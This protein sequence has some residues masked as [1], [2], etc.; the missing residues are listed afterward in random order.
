MK[1]TEKTLLRALGEADEKTV[2]KAAP[3]M[4]AED[5]ETLADFVPEQE[6]PPV[7]KRTL[8]TRRITEIGLLCAAIALCVFTGI[9]L[10]KLK[11]SV[12]SDKTAPNVQRAQA[13]LEEFLNAANAG[14]TEKIF[15]LT[16]MQTAF[17]PNYLELTEDTGLLVY[18]FFSPNASKEKEI[19]RDAHAK[20]CDS[21]LYKTERDAAAEA[22]AAELKYD[23]WKI[24]SGRNASDE[25]EIRQKRLADRRD[26]QIFRFRESGE[27]KLAER[28]V[29]R[30]SQ[31]LNTLSLNN[32]V[33]TFEV[34]WGKDG[35]QIT[36]TIDVFYYVNTFSDGAEYWEVQPFD[37]DAEPL[38]GAEQQELNAYRAKQAASG[39]SP[40][41][42]ILYEDHALLKSCD[43]T[44]CSITIPSE[45]QGLPVTGFYGDGTFMDC[46]NLTEI[47][48]ED[49][50]GQFDALAFAFTP[51]L[52]KL[53]KDN[54][55]VI[56]GD[57][58]MF[59]RYV[60]D[61]KVVIPDSVKYISDQAF[62]GNNLITSVVIPDS[63]VRIGKGAFGI[64]EN[65]SEVSIPESVT[66]IDDNAFSGCDNLTI[67][68]NKG[69]YAENYA[70][71]KGIPFQVIK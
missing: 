53:E 17:E 30:T 40:L 58:L 27:D 8:I 54:P 44:A 22:Y 66:V 35:E 39:E 24:V 38:T 69:S 29:M 13:V 25:L 46:A 47:T 64:C 7:P 18:P 62:Y 51:W 63:V 49:N 6:E 48:F 28:E 71:Q 60:T 67:R 33:F 11:R 19:S 37:L 70:Q 68:G 3:R 16:V 56:C 31:A 50:H 12:Q 59:A 23:S 52:Q 21:G 20:N 4:L 32:T 9:G 2:E 55:M 45:Y 5:F 15:E 41:K 43:V 65:L 34:T 10:V 57:T 14:N 36:D 42:Y 61:K 1:L 26:L